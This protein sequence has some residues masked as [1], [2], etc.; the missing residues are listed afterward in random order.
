MSVARTH[1]HL[2]VLVRFNEGAHWEEWHL[3]TNR[4]NKSNKPVKFSA[5]QHWRSDHGVRPIPFAATSGSY[6]SEREA[7]A[8]FSCEVAACGG[9]LLAVTNQL[10]NLLRERF[11]HSVA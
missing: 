8:Q 11:G 7:H 5:T 10:S 9:E 1:S 2:T 6:A 3:R 4:G